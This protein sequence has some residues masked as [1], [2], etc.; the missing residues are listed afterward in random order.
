MRTATKS[1]LHN[2]PFV[3]KDAAA[4]TAAYQ[5]LVSIVPAQQPA[6]QAQY[7]ASLAGIPDGSPK[8]NGI[9]LGGVA[10]DAM[11]AA[12]TNDGRFGPFRFTIGTTPGAW[13]PVLPAFI[14]DPNAWLKDVKPFM[15]QSASQFR[16]LDRSLLRAPDTRRSS[17]R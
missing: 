14:N 10:A 15:V 17:P 9:R 7:V 4:A 11:I 8:T 3:S 6:L 12:R 13:R 16:T 1:H 2:T 5:V